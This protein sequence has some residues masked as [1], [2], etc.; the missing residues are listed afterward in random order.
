MD[1]QRFTLSATSAAQLSPERP[2]YLGELLRLSPGLVDNWPAL[3]DVVRGAEPPHPVDDEDEVFHA[4]L[5]RATFG[6]QRSVAAAVVDSLGLVDRPDLRIADLG[7]GG[8]AWR[9]EGRRVGKRVS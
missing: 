6:L 4:P 7:A 3:A 9:S 5:A 8:G 2:G 1:G